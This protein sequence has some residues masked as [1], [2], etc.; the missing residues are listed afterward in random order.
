MSGYREQERINKAEQARQETE[1]ML[2]EQ[3]AEVDRKKAEM[4]RRDAER[5]RLKAIQV[6]AQHAPLDT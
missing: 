4:V 3:Q 1:N 5:E 2:K 6:H